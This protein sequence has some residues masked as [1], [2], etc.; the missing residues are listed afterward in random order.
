MTHLGPTW[1][2]VDT[3]A[4]SANVVALRE[5]I[6]DG[7]SL[8]AVVKANAY[9]HG[10]TMAAE[11]VLDAGADGLCVARA[12]EGLTLRAA[13]ID[14]PI[15]VLGWVP[16]KLAK[17]CVDARLTLTVNSPTLVEA[18]SQAAGRD[19]VPVHVKVD[20][21]MSRYGLLPDEVVPFVRRIASTPKL[22]FEGLWTH[23]ARADEADCSTSHEQLEVF[24]RIFNELVDAGLEPTLSHIAASAGLLR[25]E[26]RPAHLD[27][28]RAGIALYGLYP[29]DKVRW[30]VELKPVLTW[31]A[32]VARV[33]TLPAGTPISYGGTYVT[34]RKQ[35]VALVPAGYGDG[36]PRILSNR[37]SVLINGQRCRIL[38]RVCMDAVVVDVDHLSDVNE[39]DEIVLL[40]RQGDEVVTADELAGMLDTINYEVVTQIMDRVPRIAVNGH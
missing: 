13:G 26:L 12:D 38:G 17:R 19:P 28:V 25:R 1:L 10:A 22:R 39:G 11:T 4:L 24:N 36:Y 5:H 16:P 33:R 29:S 8:F 15:W 30:P 9:G 18:L 37:A 31:K 34:P 27:A 35:T 40:G 2:E 14:A 21:G 23:L 3:G 32:R 7:A 6:A 20:S